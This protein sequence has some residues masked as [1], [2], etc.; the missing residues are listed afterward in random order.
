MWRK[1]GGH[2]DKGDIRKVDGMRGT[3]TGEMGTT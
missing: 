1:G 3:T 2:E